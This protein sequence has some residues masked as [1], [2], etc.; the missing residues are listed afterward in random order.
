MAEPEGEAY[1]RNALESNT[2]THAQYTRES[3]SL[4][5]AQ[6]WPTLT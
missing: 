4:F 2:R 6:R 1:L 3:S 5:I